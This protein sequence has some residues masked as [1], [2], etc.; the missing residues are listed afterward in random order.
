M[1]AAQA[2]PVLFTALLV[3]LVG[4]QAV[5]SHQSCLSAHFSVVHSGSPGVLLKGAGYLSLLSIARRSLAQ[6]QLQTEPRGPGFSSAWAAVD[7]E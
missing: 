7:R 6:M 3:S 1:Q 5:P 4:G 2:S